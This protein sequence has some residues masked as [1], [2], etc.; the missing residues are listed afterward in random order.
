VNDIVCVFIAI[1][2]DCGSTLSSVNVEGYKGI[3]FVPMLIARSGQQKPC[4]PTAITTRLIGSTGI[5]RDGES[6]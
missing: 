4:N 6:D 2:R 1:V 5:E 3:L